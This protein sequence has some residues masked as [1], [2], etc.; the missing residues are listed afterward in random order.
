MQKSIEK[1]ISIVGDFYANQFFD[2]CSKKAEFL[3]HESNDKQFKKFYNKFEKV[4]ARFSEEIE[5]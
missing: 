5:E 4:G 2:R 3:M 1:Q